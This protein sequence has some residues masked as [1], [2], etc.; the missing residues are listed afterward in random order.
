MLEVFARQPFDRLEEDGV[1][2]HHQVDPLVPR[3]SGD[4]GTE[5]Q[6][7]QQ[8][9]DRAFGKSQQQPGVVPL[10]SEMRGRVLLEKLHNVANRGHTACPK[11]TGGRKREPVTQSEPVTQRGESGAE[12]SEKPDAPPNQ[13]QLNSQA[14]AR[15]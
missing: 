12:R 1:M 5:R 8:F 11:G 9:A 4:I 7:G 15:R 6:A 10:F 13:R 14:T 3:F 2:R